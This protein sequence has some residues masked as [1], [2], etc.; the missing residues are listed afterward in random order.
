M[1]RFERFLDERLFQPLGM[2]DTTFWPNE[3][4]AARIAKSYKPGPGNQGLEETTIGQ[5]YRFPSNWPPLR[6]M[7]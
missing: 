2:K 3:K 5:L 6:S 7:R 1:T 4:Q